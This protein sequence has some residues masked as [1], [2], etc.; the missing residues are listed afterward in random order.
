MRTIFTKQLKNEVSEEN[1]LKIFVE[2][3]ELHGV[4]NDSITIDIDDALVDE[5]NKAQNTNIKLEDLYKLA[6]K[7]FANEWIK[8]IYLGSK[9]GGI[10][11]TRTGLGIVRSRQLRE[12]A[13]AK[14]SRL[15]KLS[16][17]IEDHKGLFVALGTVI[18]LTTPL[19]KLFIK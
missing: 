5:I 6:D 9:Y 12:K 16:D 11:I 4:S 14:R 13:L 10:A 2:E 8:N 7:C 1:F 17:Y 18:A 15:K 3:M 19:L